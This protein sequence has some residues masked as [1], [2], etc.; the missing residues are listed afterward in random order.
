M[1]QEI[2]G[3]QATFARYWARWKGRFERS[4]VKGSFTVSR[5]LT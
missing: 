5:P 1:P 3:F 4:G 2:G